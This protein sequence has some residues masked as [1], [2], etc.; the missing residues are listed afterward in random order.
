MSRETVPVQFSEN[1]FLHMKLA[2]NLLLNE[3][4][5]NSAPKSFQ[6]GTMAYSHVEVRLRRQNF[7][8]TY[9]QLLGSVLRKDEVST[10]Q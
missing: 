5:Y 3:G 9:S 4:R 10:M 1:Y 7:P 2:E 6:A 8:F